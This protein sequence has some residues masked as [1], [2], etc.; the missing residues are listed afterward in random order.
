M[1]AEQQCTTAKCKYAFSTTQT[2]WNE[3]KG[4]GEGRENKDHTSTECRFGTS[5]LKGCL[6]W[7][8]TL[9]RD[10]R[11]KYVPKIQN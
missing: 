8:F 7:L 4:R 2:F 10:D 1:E 9:Q 6:D 3:E 11:K 5:F